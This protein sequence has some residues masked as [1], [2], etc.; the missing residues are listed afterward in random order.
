MTWSAM[1]KRSR[2]KVSV[3]A[4]RVDF[5]TGSGVEGSMFAMRFLSQRSVL[6]WEVLKG[7]PCSLRW[8]RWGERK[9]EERCRGREVP[10]GVV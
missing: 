2:M 7:R 3:A 6:D 8:V 9:A 5:A 4:R 10:C 1:V